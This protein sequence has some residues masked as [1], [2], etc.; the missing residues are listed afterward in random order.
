MTGPWTY[1]VDKGDKTSDTL[2][3]SGDTSYDLTVY[4][5]NGFFRRFAG[6]IFS[7]GPK[8][9]VR[10]AY[11]DD[12]GIALAIHNQGNSPE[13]VKIVDAYSGNTSSY[14][15]HPHSDVTA[16]EKLHKTYGWYDLTV[17]VAS[18][19]AFVRQVAGHVETGR[20]SMTD[21]AIGSV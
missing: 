13:K 20:D 16:F 4:G 7:G 21:P 18:D 2:G 5:P 10:A 3:R 15:V 17:E 1:T 19:P 8:I 14:L 9:T 12:G 6:K 11:D